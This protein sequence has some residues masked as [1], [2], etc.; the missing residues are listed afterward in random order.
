MIHIYRVIY[1][2]IG[3]ELLDFISTNTSI[4]R[5]HTYKFFKP[6]AISHPTLLFL[7]LEALMHGTIQCIEACSVDSFKNLLDQRFSSQLFVIS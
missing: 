6:R 4:T 3:L 5:G 1:N 2:S 7:Q